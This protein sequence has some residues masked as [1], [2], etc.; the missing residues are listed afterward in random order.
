MGTHLGTLPKAEGKGTECQDLE[1]KGQDVP[2]ACGDTGGWV[3]GRYE[4]GPEGTW[5]AHRGAISAH[6]QTTPQASAK[7]KKADVAVADDDLVSDSASKPVSGFSHVESVYTELHNVFQVPGKSRK[8]VPAKSS[9]DTSGGDATE[10]A[11]AGK[12]TGKGAGSAV[13]LVTHAEQIITYRTPYKAKRK[14]VAKAEAAGA[15][16]KGGST[17]K[18]RRKAPKSVEILESDEHENENEETGDD[19]SSEDGA[20]SRKFNRVRTHTLTMQQDV[21]PV[22]GRTRSFSSAKGRG[23]GGNAAKAATVSFPGM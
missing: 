12:G 19:E 1:E 4:C 9:R 14:A 3:Q 22:R 18:S 2:G 20:V 7:A 11:S 5:V 21:E 23:A 6:L 8:A 16:N 17:R 15:G 13:S 10:I